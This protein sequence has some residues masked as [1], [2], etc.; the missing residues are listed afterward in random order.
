MELGYL[1]SRT[2]QDCQCS[3]TGILLGICPSCSLLGIWHSLKSYTAYPANNPS[4]QPLKFHCRDGRPH[5]YAIHQQLLRL[6]EAVL[7]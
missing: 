5:F 3:Q 6:S 2:E 1:L 7:L 4:Q